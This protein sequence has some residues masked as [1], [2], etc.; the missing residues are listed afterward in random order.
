MPHSP[1]RRAGCSAGC[2][3]RA[4]TCPH[5]DPCSLSQTTAALPTPAESGVCSEKETANVILS[6]RVDFLEAYDVHSVNLNYSEI[7][8][9]LYRFVPLAEFTVFPLKKKNSF[10]PGLKGTGGSGG[11]AEESLPLS[12]PAVGDSCCASAG[13]VPPGASR[14]LSRGAGT[15]RDAILPKTRGFTLASENHVT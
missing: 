1:Q 8:D 13:K 5:R 6:S 7:S 14:G 3:R 15:P 9:S 2:R 4:C 12:P 10:C 11:P